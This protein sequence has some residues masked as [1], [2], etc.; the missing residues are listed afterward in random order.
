MTDTPMIAVADFSNIDPETR[1]P[2][3]IERPMNEEE[4]VQYQKDIDADAARKVAEEEEEV[5]KKADE[6]ILKDKAK[7]DPAF[8]ALTRHLGID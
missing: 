7:T 2:V 5:K 8:A 4:L 6:K 1:M 3:V